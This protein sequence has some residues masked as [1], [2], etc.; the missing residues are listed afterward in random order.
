VDRRIS[1]H[2]KIYN[3]GEMTGDDKIHNGEITLHINETALANAERVYINARDNPS[4][5]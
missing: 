3:G 1:M 4:D 5:A 2:F